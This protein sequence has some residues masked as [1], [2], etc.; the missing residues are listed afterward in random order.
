MLLQVS[1][2]WLSLCSPQYLRGFAGAQPR[3][4]R[5]PLGKIMMDGGEIDPPE[6][7]GIHLRYPCFDAKGRSKK[8]YPSQI[9]GEKW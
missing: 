6:D 8:Q 9:G 3:G 7:L 1:L 2:T 4:V 5:F